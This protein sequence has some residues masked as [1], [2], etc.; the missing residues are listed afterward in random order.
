MFTGKEDLIREAFT[1]NTPLSCC[2]DTDIIARKI[3]KRPVRSHQ[4][5]KSE[6]TKDGNGE[7]NTLSSSTSSYKSCA[8]LDD[9]F[10]EQM[11]NLN[12]SSDNNVEIGNSDCTE[13]NQFDSQYYSSEH[14]HSDA[15][16]LAYFARSA[17][18]FN[19]MLR[20]NILLCKEYCKFLEEFLHHTADNDASEI[21]KPVQSFDDEGDDNTNLVSYVPSSCIFECMNNISHQFSLVR[22]YVHESQHYLLNII[23]QSYVIEDTSNHT[24]YQK[25][26]KSL[27]LTANITYKMA[28]N[29]KTLNT[30]RNLNSSPYRLNCYEELPVLCDELL[31]L[32][33]VVEKVASEININ[34]LLRL[35]FLH[36]SVE[37]ELLQDVRLKRINNLKEC[38]SGISFTHHALLSLQ[39]FDDTLLQDSAEP[40]ASSLAVKNC[41][42]PHSSKLIRHDSNEPHA[43]TLTVQDS[44]E[45]H[46]PK[47]HAKNSNEPHTSTF[48]DQDSN[49]H[50]SK[51]S[52]QNSDLQNDP[53]FT[54]YDSNVQLQS[55]LAV[56]DSD[57]PQ[58]STSRVQDF[59]ESYGMQHQSILT[60]NVHHASQISNPCSEDFVT[61]RF[62]PLDVLDAPGVLS[63]LDSDSTEDSTLKIQEI[64]KRCEH[65]LLHRRVNTSDIDVS[66]DEPDENIFEQNNDILDKNTLEAD[67]INELNNFSSDSE[68]IDEE[69]YDEN[70]P[71]LQNLL[72]SEAKL[73]LQYA[74]YSHCP[75]CCPYA[76]TPEIEELDISDIKYQSEDLAKLMLRSFLM[77]NK[78]LKVLNVSWACIENSLVSE[79]VDNCI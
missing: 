68:I 1:P 38:L 32:S 67:A 30:N 58:K 74:K 40:H 23:N 9:F 76:Y 3:R 13:L 78:G 45:L 62:L 53:I 47:L 20:N 66:C 70:S 27:I 11:D 46:A 79:I 34:E 73:L 6:N 29:L 15:D 54:L 77:V 63:G 64:S 65:E 26:S 42:E 28:C 18:S 44:Y 59:D 2:C 36:H 57:E 19:C 55:T 17:P 75:S 35:K 21:D 8:N 10:N 12:L 48:I 7:C 24:M 25:C 61:P 43:S 5:T 33:S 69:I 31:H 22:N 14:E 60:H 4:S 41:H 72:I 71:E 52:V 51:L 37:I 16:S 49:E 56:K 50:A 39:D